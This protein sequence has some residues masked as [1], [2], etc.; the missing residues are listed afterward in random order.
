MIP[1]S[2]DFVP[3]LDASWGSSWGYVGD[4]LAIKP[5]Q[6]HF[7]KNFKKY[8]QKSGPEVAGAD[9]PWPLTTKIIQPKTFI[10]HNKGHKNTP[11]S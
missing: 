4:M 10:N 1:F 6:N 2:I 8:F 7:K 9:P 11:H 5:F 3:I